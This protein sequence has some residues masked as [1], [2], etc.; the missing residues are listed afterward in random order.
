MTVIYLKASVGSGIVTTTTSQIPVTS[1]MQ[2]IPYTPE[3]NAQNMQ[4]IQIT[5]QDWENAGHYHSCTT[6]P[7]ATA[8]VRVTGRPVSFLHMS[9][10]YLDTGVYGRIDDLF[11]HET[12]KHCKELYNEG[13]E[14]LFETTLI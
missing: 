5:R 9:F 12:Y 3:L 14:V 2:E 11:N 7:M 4:K 1:T 13:K 8:I 10:T 6:C